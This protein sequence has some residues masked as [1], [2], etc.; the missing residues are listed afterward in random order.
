MKR[1]KKKKKRKN[2]IREKATGMF[3]C[4]MYASKYCIA[5]ADGKTAGCLVTTFG[6]LEMIDF[7]LEGQVAI[8][9]VY[10]C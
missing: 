10:N 2:N 5:T 7:A 6:C 8:A 3:P 1:K 9:I 4:F